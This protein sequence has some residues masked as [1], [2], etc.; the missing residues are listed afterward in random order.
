MA[1][2][3]FRRSKLARTNYSFAKRQREIA[4][5][6]KK[7]DK[8]KAKEEAAALLAAEAEALEAAVSGEEE[9]EGDVGADDGEAPAA[10][11]EA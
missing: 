9:K 10:N 6:K 11:L 3:P 5:K 4:K 7:E 1:L 2:N 8:K